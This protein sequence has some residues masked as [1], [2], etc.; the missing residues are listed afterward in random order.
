MLGFR[1]IFKTFFS[2]LTKQA[3]G[4]DRIVKAAGNNSKDAVLL[5]IA[6]KLP[7]LV[8]LQVEAIK[9]IKIDKITVWE[10]GS[11]KEGKTATSNFISGMYGSVPPLQEMFNMAGMELPEYLKGKKVEDGGDGDLDEE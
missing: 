1:L 6:D 4:F 9:N 2:R 3:E 8:K 11:S 10:N 5:L 7:K